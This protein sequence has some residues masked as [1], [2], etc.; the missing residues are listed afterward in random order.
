M[1]IAII[2]AKITIIAIIGNNIARTPEVLFRVLCADKNGGI[3][4]RH[5]QA[6]M[7][8]HSHTEGSLLVVSTLNSV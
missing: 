7:H 2:I 3:R 8:G 5:R 6:G 4:L 1:V